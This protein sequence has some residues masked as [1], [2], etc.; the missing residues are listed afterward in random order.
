MGV[1]MDRWVHWTLLSDDERVER[2]WLY[3]VDY[4][5]AWVA[6]APHERLVYG[7]STATLD[8]KNPRDAELVRSLHHL[9]T[10]AE[11]GVPY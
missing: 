7:L 10:V 1:A 2:A 4:H 8:P 3:G 9:T 11:P 6:H 5:S